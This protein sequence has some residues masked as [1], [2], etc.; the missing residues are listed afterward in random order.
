MDF[1]SQDCEIPI[2]MLGLF[3]ARAGQEL[4]WI[5]FSQAGERSILMLVFFSP[6]GW[7]G[8]WQDFHFAPSQKPSIRDRRPR[9]CWAD[10]GH[11]QPRRSRPRAWMDLFFAACEIKILA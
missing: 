6:A 11:A 7:P 5:F 2:I 3:A 9:A 4:G 1:L 10:V 8:S